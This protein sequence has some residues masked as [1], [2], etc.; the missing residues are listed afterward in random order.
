[1]KEE[2]EAAFVE[3]FASRRCRGVG[4]FLVIDVHAVLRQI[5]NE[6]FSA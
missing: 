5:F 3:G 6:M 4:D 1:M 2:M